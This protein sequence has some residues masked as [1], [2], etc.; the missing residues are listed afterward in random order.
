MRPFKR[1]LGRAQ[2]IHNTVKK[3]DNPKFLLEEFL[4]GSLG[5]ELPIESL[6][7]ELPIENNGVEMGCLTT[8]IGSGRNSS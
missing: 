1:P 5:S 8:L 3:F 6:G 2:N 4:T 7:S